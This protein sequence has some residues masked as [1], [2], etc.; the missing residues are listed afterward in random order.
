MRAPSGEVEAGSPPGG[1][2]F[3]Q[4]RVCA[5][6]KPAATFAGMR[7]RHGV[8]EDRSKA[9]LWRKNSSPQKY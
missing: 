7:A 8:I 1:R 9:S 6:A 5:G 3:L 2:A 4:E